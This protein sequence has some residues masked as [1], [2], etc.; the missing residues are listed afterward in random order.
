MQTIEELI[1]VKKFGRESLKAFISVMYLSNRLADL[2]EQFFEEFNVT[3]QQFNVLRILRGVAPNS[4]NQSFIK[5]RIIDRNSDMSRMIQRMIKAKLVARTVNLDDKRSF[6]VR[7]TE[8]GL[9]ILHRIDLNVADL[10]SSFGNL[11][12][13]ELV[14]L[15]G[16]LGKVL[17]AYKKDN[18]IPK[19][20]NKVV[21][22]KAKET[23]PEKV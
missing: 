21:A 11:N 3:P 13:E 2:Q 15:T 14:Q 16:L 4:A 12:Q 18:S 23:I 7:I 5:D 19:K 22:R 8:R 20:I 17:E 1:H 9:T 6:N 10:E